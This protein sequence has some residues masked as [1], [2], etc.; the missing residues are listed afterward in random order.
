MEW[1][2]G[3]EFVTDLSV[4]WA[5]LDPCPGDV[6]EVFLRGTDMRDAPDAVWASFLIADLQYSDWGVKYCRAKFIG[7]PDAAASKELSSKFNRRVGTLHLC[8]SRPC[9]EIAGSFT[10]HVTQ[11]KWWSFEAFDADYITP[12]IRRQVLK[13]RE[14]IIAA[15]AG[16]GAEQPPPG[17]EP[18]VPG[19]VGAMPKS[20]ANPGASFVYSP[21]RLEVPEAGEDPHG[22]MPPGLELP[23]QAPPAEGDPRRARLQ[24]RLLEVREKFVPGA[25]AMR[26]PQAG[27]DQPD[28]RLPAAP[29]GGLRRRLGG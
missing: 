4:G 21:E 25:A 20:A 1:Q 11:V 9:V 18:G 12:A 10:L 8:L 5:L 23:P 27:Q 16:L 17:P 28:I 13:W 26:E 3:K 19:P 2:E 22:L 7:C 29:S 24:Q 15:G 6:L 14:A